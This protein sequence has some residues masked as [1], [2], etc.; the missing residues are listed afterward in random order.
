ME[1]SPGS[2]LHRSV[3]DSS[4]LARRSPALPTLGFLV[5]DA[6]LKSFS[7]N[8]E[9]VAILTYPGMPQIL[10]ASFDEK[11]RRRLLRAQ[12]SPSNENGA[13]PAIQFK[14]GRRTYFARAFVLNEGRASNPATVLIV[15]ERGISASLALSQV[16][17]QFRLT[18]REQE[19]VTLLLEGLGN[20]G[21]AD[22]MRVSPNTVKA[23]LRLVMIK[24]GVASR[25]AIVAKVLDMVL[26]SQR[27][28]VKFVPP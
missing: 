16:F 21:M 11:I 3:Q 14:S 24:M 6:S 1:T 23:F 4:K 10:A 19:V 13:P 18:Q 28:G 17:Q 15:L 22:R 20:K 12:H 9:A 27:L 7:A 5:A 25:S 2:Q 8:H 26:S